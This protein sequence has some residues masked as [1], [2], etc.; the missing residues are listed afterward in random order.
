MTEERPRQEELP[1][2][3]DQPEEPIVAQPE[4]SG[5]N[6][7]LVIPVREEVPPGDD[8]PLVE[9]VPIVS[10]PE[11][12]AAPTVEPAPVVSSP[13]EPSAQPAEPVVPPEP[14]A[15]PVE[16]VVAQDEPVLAELD[17]PIEEPIPDGGVEPPAAPEA[18]PA[19]DSSILLPR[20]EYEG[21]GTET[22]L[23]MAVPKKEPKSDAPIP[24][25][26]P[27]PKPEPEP[28]NLEVIVDKPVSAREETVVV[29]SRDL[30]SETKLISP[31]KMLGQYVI[32][33]HLA[34]GGMGNIWMA[35][36]PFEV[37]ERRMM[38]DGSRDPQIVELLAEAKVTK[39][40]SRE[41]KR[42]KIEAYLVQKKLD[43][44]AL[45]ESERLRY[46]MD[47][48]KWMMD[49]RV[50]HVVLKTTLD[51]ARLSRFKRE[52][53]ICKDLDHPNIVKIKGGGDDRGI[54]YAVFEY[55]EGKDLDK[56]Q[57]TNEEASKVMQGVL[58]GLIYAHERKILHRDIKPANIFVSNNLK[59]V[60]LADFGLAKDQSAIWDQ[61]ETGSQDHVMGT[62]Q[63]MSPEQA[64]GEHNSI[65]D[66]S[67]VFSLGATFYKALTGKPPAQGSN[68]FETLQMIG[69]T[70]D[71]P[72]W[73][74]EFKPEVSE[75]L[76][77]LVM[78]MLSKDINARL[79]TSEAKDL[80]GKIVKEGR[81]SYRPVTKEQSQTISQ[82]RRV[83]DREIRTLSST[84]A[85]IS[86]S[87]KTPEDLFLLARKYESAGEIY[88]RRDGIYLQS[89]VKK[90]GTS[91]DGEIRKEI[92][93]RVYKSPRL[94]AFEHAVAHYEEYFRSRPVGKL[95]QEQLMVKQFDLPL[96]IKKVE[97]EKRR[98]K[99]VV[100][101]EGVKPVKASR[102]KAAGI[103]ALVAASVIGI[104]TYFVLDHKKQKRIEGQIVEI[105]QA[106]G[107][108][109]FK[110]AY[111]KLS[112]AEEQAKDY[113]SSHG[114]NQRLKELRALV[115]NSDNFDKVTALYASAKTSASDKSDFAVSRN[116]LEEALMTETKLSDEFKAR[117]DD[118][119]VS[120]AGELYKIMSKMLE[121]RNYA[122]ASVG[123]DAIKWF[124]NK[125][126][127]KSDEH[128]KLVE[129]LKEKIRK[130]EPEI[131]RRIGDIKAFQGMVVDLLNA[132]SA[133]YE[134]LE[135]QLK[136]DKF[137]K[138]ADLNGIDEKLNKVSEEL[139]KIDPN[140]VGPEDYE[141]RKS[142]VEGMKGKV[143]SLGNELDGRQIA[144]LKKA[145]KELDAIVSGVEDY[146]NDASVQKI[147]VA[148]AS[149]DAA[150]EVYANVGQ[151]VAELKDV[152]GQLNLVDTK[153]RDLDE[154]ASAYPRNLRLAKDGSD[155]EKREARSN[156][157]K[158]YVDVGRLSDAEKVL[159]EIP[160]KAGLEAYASIVELEKKVVDP[161]LLVKRTSLGLDQNVIDGYSASV[162][163]Y[164]ADNSRG[165]KL[166]A[167]LLELYVKT[168]VDIKAAEAGIKSVKTL[169]NRIAELKDL[170]KNDPKAEYL[171]EL[172][173]KEKAHSEQRD[174]LY[175][176]LDTYSAAA[177]LLLE[178]QGKMLPPSDLIKR[179]SD[180]YRAARYP[181]RAD[182]VLERFK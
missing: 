93:E 106:H 54:H 6:I 149:M 17:D 89:S 21:H 43:F 140:A 157:V 175:K 125:I 119:K 45:P 112:E 166:A 174:S 63:F 78:M 60:K 160:D 134:K 117:L 94:D 52:I 72:P 51:S 11:E 16:S 118:V 147:K 124:L 71:D 39:G 92:E 138:R 83:L 182:A 165:E 67:D 36:D 81:S 104:G 48:K 50:P 155:G 41:S 164:K 99:R 3:G 115:E 18:A 32:I 34:K 49:S 65:V 42:G 15:Q 76:E 46:V 153:L 151:N 22:I 38:E 142:A 61:K 59:V 121:D 141:K 139:S 105:E 31:G 143:K 68:T 44:T 137:F 10:P 178:A 100:Q 8:K 26:K 173:E 2:E 86:R 123:I 145:T 84:V 58:E 162:E 53:N 20:D 4:K 122:Q 62:P 110:L 13:E 126:S 135:V 114:L 90:N 103:A 131:F 128:A 91:A 70:L 30:E 179:L 177:K 47:N 107:L 35:V 28:G 154:K 66:K 25:P 19:Q 161:A 113:A 167:S 152:E 80:L 27:E 108:G 120:T 146:T 29:D 74:R 14:A 180:S 9:P 96:L 7:P 87:G 57:L 77:D 97:L 40:D 144:Y 12:P 171:R 111:D 1:Q 181:N 56:L 109:N 5:D 64:R 102:M 133:D 69:L 85:K 156:L 82:E 169:T 95:S 73:I 98:L 176:A 101:L 37:L 172:E 129:S 163:A 136:A 75:E 24:A 170:I 168:N 33:R 148:K 159:N 55:V 132:V 116:S 79:S 150:K 88:G 158:T 127:P 130:D 23:D